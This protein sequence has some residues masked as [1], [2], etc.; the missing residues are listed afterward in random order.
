MGSYQG[1]CECNNIWSWEVNFCAQTKI[2]YAQV[3]YFYMHLRIN[4]FYQQLYLKENYESIMYFD[5]CKTKCIL[6]PNDKIH[7]FS[8]NEILRIKSKLHDDWITEFLD[9]LADQLLLLC[10]WKQTHCK[11]C[12]FPVSKIRLQI[13]NR[14][15]FT[16]FDAWHYFV[17]F[18]VIKSN[19]GSG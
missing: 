9:L 11:C 14:T 19:I 18:Y 7:V 5:S 6:T 8:K 10:S 15:S 3:L 2:S 16:N 12:H 4:W 17:W 13:I 1:V